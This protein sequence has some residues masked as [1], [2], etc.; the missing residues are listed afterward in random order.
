MV[1][2]TNFQVAAYTRSKLHVSTLGLFCDVSTF[3][4]LPNV[5]FFHLT[6][7]S[8]RSAFRL[9]VTADQ[10]VRFLHVH[11]HPMLRSGDQP[12]VPSNVTGQIL[13]WDKERHR[14]VMDEVRQPQV[15][16]KFCTKSLL[17]STSPISFLKVWVHQCK[18]AAEFSATRQFT[19]DLDALAWAAAHTNKRYIHIHYAEQVLAYIGR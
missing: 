1:V 5:I 4:R 15:F 3:R 19:S 14:V 17:S 11:A 9:G 18:D 8:I 12:L 2:Q 7:D 6:R 13:L 10:I 16:L